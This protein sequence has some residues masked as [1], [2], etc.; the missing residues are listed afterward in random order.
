M[1]KGTF[2]DFA[3]V[4]DEHFLSSS[5]VP[6]DIFNGYEKLY[7]YVIFHFSLKPVHLGIFYI[8]SITSIWVQ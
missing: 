7:L 2:I 4:S 6:D 1:F 3:L 8:A 5:S